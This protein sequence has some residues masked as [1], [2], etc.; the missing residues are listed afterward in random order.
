MHIKDYQKFVADGIVGDNNTSR[1]LLLLGATGLAGEAGEVID[2]IFHDGKELDMKE[3]LIELGDV[4]WYIT[5]LANVLGFSL[6]SIIEVN[7]SKLVNRYPDKHPELL[8]LYYNT[9]SELAL[10]SGNEVV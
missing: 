1:D 3:L 2:H 7:V 5:L 10:N 8:D 9:P 4:L 6:D